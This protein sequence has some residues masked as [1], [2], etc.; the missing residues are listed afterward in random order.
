MSL[1]RSGSWTT[2]S[3][4]STAASVTADVRENIRLVYVSW[5]P[6]APCLSGDRAPH[7]RSRAALSSVRLLFAALGAQ[8]RRTRAAQLCLRAFGRPDLLFGHFTDERQL[9]AVALE[10]LEH[11]EEPEAE[12]AEREQRPAEEPDEAGDPAEEGNA[13]AERST[14]PCRRSRGPSPRPTPASTA[15]RGTSRIGCRFR[16]RRKSRR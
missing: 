9:E 13:A 5:P 11:A 10:G 8:R 3:A 15:W 6:H 14:R 12:Q 4:S 7:A 16:W 1:W 2:R